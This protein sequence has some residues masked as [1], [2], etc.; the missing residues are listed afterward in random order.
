MR[1]EGQS[2]IFATGNYRVYLYLVKVL[3]STVVK[4]LWFANSYEYC[5]INMWKKCHLNPSF[6][7][8]SLELSSAVGEKGIKRGQMGK[9]SASEAGPAVPF[10]LPRL[11]LSRKEKSFTNDRLIVRGLIFKV[12]VYVSRKWASDLCINFFYI[13]FNLRAPFIPSRFLAA[14]QANREP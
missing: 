13:C 11:P 2:R 5:Q 8:N 1:N 3:H 10:S 9:I 7:F 4:D 14:Q 12:R 6:C